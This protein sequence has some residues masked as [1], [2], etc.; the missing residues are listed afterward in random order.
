MYRFAMNFKIVAQRLMQ[1][2]TQVDLQPK[3]VPR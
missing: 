1:E 3:V 2:S